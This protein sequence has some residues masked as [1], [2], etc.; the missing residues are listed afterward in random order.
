M[1][2]TPPP[3]ARPRSSHRTYRWIRQIHLWIGAWG[4][5]AA[6]I[7]GYTGLVMNHRMG[8]NP[9]PQGESVDAG[10]VVLEVPQPARASAEDLSKWLLQTQGLDAHT[11]R[12]GAPRGREGGPE[13]WTLSGGNARESWSL[14]YKP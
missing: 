5:I 14:Q 10:R 9:W 7:Y 2:P 4:A 13:Q 3:H 12:K 1:S 11:N 6:I 8:D